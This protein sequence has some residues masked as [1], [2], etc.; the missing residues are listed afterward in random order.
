M[1][2]K[3]LKNPSSK[4]G[5]NVIIMSSKR[6]AL[7]DFPKWCSQIFKDWEQEANPY[8]EFR[9]KDNGTAEKA[10]QLG[11]Y[12]CQRDIKQATR[13]WAGLED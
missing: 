10:W 11:Y 12:A 4:I 6:V 3:M 8:P 13:Q 2:D 5:D 1:L 9:K 7:I